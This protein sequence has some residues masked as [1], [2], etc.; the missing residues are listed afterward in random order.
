MIINDW[1]EVPPPRNIRLFSANG[2][3]FP[4][5]DYLRLIG[6]MTTDEAVEVLRWG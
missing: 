5:D 1:Y 2:V 4:L 6:Q 3:P